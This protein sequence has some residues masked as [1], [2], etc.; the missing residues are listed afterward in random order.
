MV[1][2]KNR[3]TWLIKKNL[4]HLIVLIELEKV[5]LVYQHFQSFYK[6]FGTRLKNA[7]EERILQ[8]TKLVK[9]YYDHPEESNS[10]K[11]KH[12]LETS[13]LSDPEKPADILMLGFYAWIKSKVYQSRIKSS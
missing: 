8:F 2:E 11:L 5:D 13:F 3:F 1:R 4:I 9:A 10:E 6:R 12:Q 7:G